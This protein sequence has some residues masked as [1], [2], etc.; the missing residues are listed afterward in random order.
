MIEQE[1]LDDTQTQREAV[2][3]RIRHYVGGGAIDPELREQRTRFLNRWFDKF[4]G[5]AAERQA[6]AIADLLK[7]YAAPVVSNR[8]PPWVGRRAPLTYL[9]YRVNQLLGRPFDE[10]LIERGRAAP[11]DFL[12]QRDK[13]V[14]QRDVDIWERRIR[15]VLAKSHQAS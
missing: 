14:R 11:L 12:G 1:D 15:E 8:R 5:H 3:S 2:A 6:A 10:P 9:H 7:N 13:V 4:D